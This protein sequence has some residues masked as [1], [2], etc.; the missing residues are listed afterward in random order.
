MPDTKKQKQKKWY[1]KLRNKYRLVILNDESYEEKFSFR[2]SRLNVFVTIGFT[3]I[4]LITITI[5]LIAFTPLREYIP[6]YTDVTLSRRINDLLEK[7]DSLENVSKQKAAY[8]A[9]IRRIIEGEDIPYDSLGT[10]PQT[11]APDPDQI[12]YTRSVEDS[13]LRQ[14]YRVETSFDLYYN[15]NDELNSS[16]QSLSSQFFF[17]PLEGIVTSEFDLGGKHYGIDIVSKPNETVKATLDGTVIFADWSI[18][19]G[20]TIAIQHQGNFISVYKH[21]SVLLKEQGAFVKAG[22][23]VAIVGESGE[24]STGAHLHF[25][26][27]YNGTPVNPRDYVA[28]KN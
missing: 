7:T 26:L 25:E 16:R 12:N 6:G 20:Y 11:S 27:W 17:N 22:D 28:F 24:L 21:N 4:L 8:L 2:L 5:F 13:L 10:I 14:D 1:F 19:T 23:P 15:D 3:A 18:E 9:N